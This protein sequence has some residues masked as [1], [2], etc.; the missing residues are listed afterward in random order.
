[1]GDSYAA[2]VNGELWLYAMHISPYEQ[3][4]RFNKD[5]MRTRRLLLHKNEILRLYGQTRIEGLTLVP[6]KLY[7]KQA[8]SKSKSAWPEAKRPMTSGKT[9]RK[10]GQP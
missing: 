8:G 1:M 10:A 6:T 3:G 5:P 7:F 9:R 2:V 4:N